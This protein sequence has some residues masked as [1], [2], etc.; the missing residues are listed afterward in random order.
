MDDDICF[1]DLVESIDAESDPTARGIVQCL[2][3]LAEEAS[4]LRLRRT[5]AA[6]QAAMRICADEGETGDIIALL[7]DNLRAR[8]A[9]LH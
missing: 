9:L 5:L 4:S 2:R 6:L 8:G 1:P 7:D 3:M